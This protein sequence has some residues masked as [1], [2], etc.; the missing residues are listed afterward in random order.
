MRGFCAISSLSVR[1]IAA[2]IVSGLPS[3]A[4]GASNDALV[5]STSG[6]YTHSP[7]VSLPGLRRL[8]RGV[9]GLADLAIDVLR[10]RGE[11][12]V[13]REPGVLQHRREL[14]DRIA[15]RFVRALAGVLYS[16]SSSESECEYGRMHIAW[17]SAGPLRARAHATASLIAS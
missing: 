13:G 4:A 11:I 10:N 1:L 16:F 9:G 8:E 5:G 12:R 3:G 15:L 7:A 17:T 6:E 2:T 14:R